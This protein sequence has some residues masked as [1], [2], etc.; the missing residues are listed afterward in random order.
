MTHAHP[1]IWK[2]ITSLKADESRACKRL[3]EAK[4]GV[5]KSSAKYRRLNE[6]LKHMV[7]NYDKEDQVGFLIFIHGRLRFSYIYVLL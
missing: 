4:Q 2:L 7:I 1:T 3:I 6:K 5:Y